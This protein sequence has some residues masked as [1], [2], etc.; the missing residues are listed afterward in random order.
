MIVIM[1]K[2]K[3]G[4]FY[5]TAEG[6]SKGG[7]KEGADKTMPSRAGSLAPAMQTLSLRPPGA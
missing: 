7:E 1:G 2:Q 6:V 3:R 4:M 5:V